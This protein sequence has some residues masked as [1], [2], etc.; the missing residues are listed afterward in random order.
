MDQTW[1]EGYEGFTEAVLREYCSHFSGRKP[2]LELAPIYEA[3]SDL[4]ELGRVLEMVDCTDDADRAAVARR[5][6]AAVGYLNSALAGWDER[7]AADEAGRVVRAAGGEVP[8]RQAT[9]VLAEEEDRAA[10]D[11]LH[12]AWLEG[13]EAANPLRAEALA[14]ERDYLERL[15]LGD[16]PLEAWTKLN[17]LDFVAL[18]DRL[19]PAAETLRAKYLEDMSDLCERH[20][21]RRLGAVAGHDAHRVARMAWTDHLFPAEGVVPALHGLLGGLGYDPGAQE[22]IE[23][24]LE[25]RPLKSPRAFCSP[26]RIPEEVVLVTCPRGGWA[27][28]QS[29][30]HELGHAQHFGTTDKELPFV[31]RRGD[32]AGTSEVFAFLFDALMTDPLWLEE[33]LGLARADAAEVARLQRLSRARMIR[34]YVAKLAYEIRVHTRFD[35]GEAAYLYS[36]SLTEAT[37]FP[38]DPRDFLRDLDRGMYVAGYLRAWFAEAQLRAA[39]RDRYGERWWASPGAGEFLGVL[40]QTGGSLR[41]EALVER[42]TGS[43]WSPDA[44]VAELAA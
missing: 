34:R 32:D 9:I 43:P 2:E 28:Y 29:A 42:A 7:V 39:L 25:P 24:D 37:G 4:F 40:W 33:S 6:A 14:A 20:V 8:F 12:E 30:L 35:E 19:Q 15:G 31:L 36:E 17:G 41:T 1:E 21:G 13:V 18:L 26:I 23:Y 3:H 10:R 27:D 44:L 22:N 38:T 16:T 5:R 11:A